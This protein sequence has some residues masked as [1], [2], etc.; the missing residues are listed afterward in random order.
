MGKV[1][2]RGLAEPPAELEPESETI[3]AVKSI[4]PFISGY[5]MDESKGNYLAYR[6]TG[7]SMREACEMA[8]IHQQT[9]QRWRGRLKH[10]KDNHDPKFVELENE[11]TGNNRV[12]IRAETLQIL[13]SRN[14]HLVLRRDYDVIRRISGLETF[15]SEDG[16]N[17]IKRV[18]SKE[19]HIYMNR[20]R[21]YYTPQQMDVIE[22]L[23]NPNTKDGDGFSFATFINELDEGSKTEPMNFHAEETIVK[24]TIDVEISPDGQ[25]TDI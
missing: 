19:D 3:E 22:R 7:F 8:G 5:A 1:A 23:A 18:A 10:H 25:A 2:R 11:V 13:F 16:E 4:L 14:F 9:V 24:R 21:A 20:I 12:R 17:E 6:F 15:K